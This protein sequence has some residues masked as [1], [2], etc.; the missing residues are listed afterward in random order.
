MCWRRTDDR[1]ACMKQGWVLVTNKKRRK[2]FCLH[3]E[4]THSQCTYSTISQISLL[5][6]VSTW[7]WGC[8]SILCSLASDVPILRQQIYRRIFCVVSQQCTC[9]LSPGKVQKFPCW[10]LRNLI[11]FVLYCRRNSLLF[12]FQP[13]SHKWHQ[14]CHI[15]YNEFCCNNRCYG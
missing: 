8:F 11:A 5:A 13:T 4:G 2:K 3:I 7:N 1:H 6:T 9:I 12:G 15:L 14:L 10:F